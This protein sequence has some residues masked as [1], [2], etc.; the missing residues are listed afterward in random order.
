MKNSDLVCI[1]DVRV[2]YSIYAIL[3][4]SEDAV[5]TLRLTYQIKLHVF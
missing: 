1:I 3:Q 5:L 4:E 2:F